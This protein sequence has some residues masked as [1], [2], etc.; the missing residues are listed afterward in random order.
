MTK[1]KK[2]EPKMKFDD[3]EPKDPPLPP[4]SEEAP[5]LEERVTAIEK[6]LNEHF[7]RPGCPVP[8]PE[9]DDAGSQRTAEE[10][11]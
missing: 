10:V 7:G 5:S 2:K 9:D 1:K 6:F 4:D 3:E 8:P 11:P